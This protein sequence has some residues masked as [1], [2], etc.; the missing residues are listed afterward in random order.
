M[1]SKIDQKSTPRAIQKMLIFDLSFQSDLSRFFVVFGGQVDL[2][3]RVKMNSRC[4]PRWLRL[5]SWKCTKT[6]VKPILLALSLL[7]HK[8]KNRWKSSP[9]P[10]P[11]PFKNRIKNQTIPTSIFRRFE[12][13][14]ALIFV[15]PRWWNT[16]H[17]WCSTKSL[18]CLQ[19]KGI[20]LK[21]L[22]T[23]WL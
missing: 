8:L 9:N 22:L 2:Q 23:C 3:N 5:N 13:D 18:H 10:I 14:F 20:L 16:W 15:R 19:V 12:I 21:V 6:I 11:K 17:C 4:I 7:Q 1:A